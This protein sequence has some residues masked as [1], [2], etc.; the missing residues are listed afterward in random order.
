MQKEP[1]QITF[2]T[3]PFNVLIY[4]LITFLI[5]VYCTLTKAL[6]SVPAFSYYLLF[7]L[8]CF[9]YVSI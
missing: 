7:F 2:A 1:W 5:S 8:S 4:T 3:A 6:I 9:F